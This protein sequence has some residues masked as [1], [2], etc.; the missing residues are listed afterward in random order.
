MALDSSNSSNLEQLALKGLRVINIGDSEP[1]V[2][3]VRL[4]SDYQCIECHKCIL[5][6]YLLIDV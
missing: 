6:A 1:L 4:S 3:P 2:I 5:L